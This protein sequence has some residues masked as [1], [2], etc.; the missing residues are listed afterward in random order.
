MS[1]PKGQW[2]HENQ[3]REML[4]AMKETLADQDAHGEAQRRLGLCVELIAA[5]SWHAF[6][7]KMDR[8][9]VYARAAEIAKEL[10]PAE[11]GG[12]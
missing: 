2:P 11:G 3:H 4:L 9:A 5:T 8:D 6:L 7:P 10:W 12:E 1:D